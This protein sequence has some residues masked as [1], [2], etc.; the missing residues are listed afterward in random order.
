MNESAIRSLLARVAAGEATPEE[1]LE[2]MRQLPFEDIGFAKID[3]H[4]TLRCGAP[5]VVFCQGKTPEQ[6]AQIAERIV[7]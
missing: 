6:V 4:R 2:A 3:H 5:E 7:A 1:A